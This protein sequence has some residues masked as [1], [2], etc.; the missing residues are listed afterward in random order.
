MLR[1]TWK[2]WNLRQCSWECKMVLPLWKIVWKFCKKEN[3][4]LPHVTLPWPSNL[5][6]RC[7]PKRNDSI[8]SHKNLY[9][10]VHSSF[11]HS[12]QKVEITQVSTACPCNRILSSNWKDWVL[13]RGTRRISLGNTVLNKRRQSPWITYCMVPSLWKYIMC[14]SN[15]RM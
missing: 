13:T 14:N 1:R 6:S 3:K 8:C 7:I 12:D 9:T 10:N 5:T 4:E 2:N 11:I 15:I